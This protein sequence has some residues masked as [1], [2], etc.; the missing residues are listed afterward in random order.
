[1]Y[2][3]S[4]LVSVVMPVKACNPAFLDKSVESVLNQTLTDLELVVVMEYG[5]QSA[6]K[7]ALDLLEKFSNDERLR[8]V[9]NKKKG[10]VEALNYGLLASRGEYIARMDGDDISLP[11]RLEMQVSAV[12]QLHLDMVGGWAYVIDEEGSTIG[13]LM[14]NFE[15]LSIRRSIMLYNPFIHSTVLFKKSILLRSGLYN[16]SLYG[17]EDYDL[18][19]RIISLGY[20]YANLPAFVIL[21]RETNNSVMRGIHWKT[22]RA[23]YARTKALGLVRLGYSDPLSVCFCF[24]SPFSLLIG[25]KMA[26]DLKCLFK[27]FKKDQTVNL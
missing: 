16:T 3:A 23:N 13:R 2:T 26:S 8:I 19:L 22:T 27:L 17:A 5:G 24:A 6:D 7:P 9:Y 15:A 18:W 1:M 4:P 12:K 11:T 20:K 25:P 10:F 21:L 14:P